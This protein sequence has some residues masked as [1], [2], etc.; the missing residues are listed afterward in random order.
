MI[1]TI[2]R[3]FFFGGGFGRFV[4]AA[5]FEDKGL[6]NGTRTE[7]KRD[8]SPSSA[9]DLHQCCSSSVRPMSLGT[10]FQAG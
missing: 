2:A 1:V 4:V 3:E 8:F 6:D 5:E 9:V 7:G 10:C